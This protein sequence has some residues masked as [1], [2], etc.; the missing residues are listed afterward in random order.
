MN[1]KKG[2]SDRVVEV[3]NR[4]LNMAI[5][6]TLQLDDARWPLNYPIQQNDICLTFTVR[7]RTL[8]QAGTP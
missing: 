7:I 6:R 1:F 4:L 2:S 3:S 5:E 8:K